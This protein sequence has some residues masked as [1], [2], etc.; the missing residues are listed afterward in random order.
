[1]KKN[2]KLKLKML[3]KI[4]KRFLRKIQKLKQNKKKISKKRANLKKMK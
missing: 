4:P 1:M 3:M 2:P